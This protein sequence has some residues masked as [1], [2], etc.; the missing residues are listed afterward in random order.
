M[1][2]PPESVGL[3]TNVLLAT[4]RPD[5]PMHTQ[6]QNA[7]RTLRNQGKALVMTPLVVAEFWSVATRPKTARN[8]LGISIT[9]IE[10]IAN[11]L[12]ARFPVLLDRP[13]AHAIWKDLATRYAVVGTSVHD[14]R[15]VAAMLAHGV[16]RLLTFDTA[17]FR[18]YREIEV[19]DPAAFA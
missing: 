9:R 2:E 1:T 11:D 4:I 8:G 10:R 3:D 16:T 13:E 5:E 19:L 12:E 17:D 15:L 6:A 18:R 7:L 14:A